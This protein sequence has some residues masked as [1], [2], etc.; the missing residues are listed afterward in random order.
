MELWTIL[1][2]LMYLEHEVHVYAITSAKVKKWDD[3]DRSRIMK[4][5]SSNPVFIL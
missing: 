4:M 5:I 1:S 2:Y 3:V